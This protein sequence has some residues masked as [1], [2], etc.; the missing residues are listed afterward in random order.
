MEL[1]EKVHDPTLDGEKQEIW[2]LPSTEHATAAMTTWLGRVRDDAS[3]LVT[4]HH[5]P[6][7]QST[8]AIEFAKQTS[9][10]LT[11]TLAL[12]GWASEDSGWYYIPSSL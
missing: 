12:A 3:P 8:V 11:T 5:K 9:T 6:V 4:G 7:I 1:R 2:F 10:A